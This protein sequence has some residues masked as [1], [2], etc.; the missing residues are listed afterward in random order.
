MKP[1]MKAAVARLYGQ[2]LTIEQVPEPTV[3]PGQILVNVAAYGVC[4]TN[5]ECMMMDGSMTTMDKMMKKSSKKTTHK[6][7]KATS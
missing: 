4:I 6:Q 7:H 3:V 5:G 2:S 1:T